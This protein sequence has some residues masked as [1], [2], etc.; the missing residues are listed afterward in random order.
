MISGSCRQEPSNDVQPL[1]FAPESGPW[2]GGMVV[3]V[4]GPCFNPNQDII[5]RFDSQTVIGKYI[6]Q[7]RSMCIMPRIHTSGYIDL[8]VSINGGVDFNWKGRFFV[9]T[10]VFFFEQQFEK[11]LIM[12]TLDF[13]KPL[14][15]I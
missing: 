1:V 8:S 11:T 2:M 15:G 6:D 9:G 3:N 12:R 14:G 4:T 5:C 7:H 13:R 10:R